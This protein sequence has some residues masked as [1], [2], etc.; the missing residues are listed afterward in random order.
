MR[1][2]TSSTV[3]SAIQT[4]YQ[5]S[6][7]PDHAR[8]ALKS[9]VPSMESGFNVNTIHGDMAVSGDDAKALMELLLQRL[10]ARQ[11]TLKHKPE[12]GRMK[13]GTGHDLFKGPL[14]LHDHPGLQTDQDGLKLKSGVLALPGELDQHVDVRY[15]GFYPNLKRSNA[16]FEVRDESGNPHHFFSTAFRS[17]TA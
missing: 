7:K 5:V 4:L 12:P 15:M 6:L 14:V 9:M 11:V 3:S 17:L 2:A 10:K 8:H 13:D 16:L 1:K